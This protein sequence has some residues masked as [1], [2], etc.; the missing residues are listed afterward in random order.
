MSMFSKM[1]EMGG[2]FMKGARQFGASASAAGKSMAKE[3]RVRGKLGVRTAKK[4]AAKAMDTTPR[5][6]GSK[7][8]GALSRL[9]KD[10]KKMKKLG[11][12]L[13]KYGVAAGAGYG[14]AKMMG[15]KKNAS[16]TDDSKK[17]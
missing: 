13:A 9:S 16:G 12:S 8:K 4:G 11:K 7:L 6:A 2:K 15:G 10:P 1:G 14:A 3:A 5:A 17:Y